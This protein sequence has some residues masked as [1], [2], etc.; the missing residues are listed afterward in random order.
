MDLKNLIRVT[1]N[2]IPVLVPEGSTILDAAKRAEVYI[3]TLCHLKLDDFGIENKPSSCRV[4]MVEV[5]GR[6]RLCTACSETA[7]DGMVVSTNSQR[8]LRARRT[9]VELLLSNHPQLCLTCAKNMDCELQ[10]LAHDIGC[11]EITYSGK[12]SHHPDD[13]TSYS[14]ISHPDKCIMCRRCETMCNEV[15]TVGVL[16]ALDRGF[17]TVVRTA[18]HLDMTETSCTKCGQC[19]AV[20]PTGALT[21]TN[22]THRVWRALQDPSKH[23]VVQVAPAVRVALGEMFGM[24]A[25][26]ISTGKIC[27]ALRKLGF[28]GIFDTDWAAD[29]TIMEEA[30]EIVH[31]LSTPGS[32][33][34]IL[35]SCCPAWVYFV[36]SQF[37]DMLDIP[38]TCK[39]PQIM[40]GTMA[41]TYYA[42]QK[43]LDPKDIVVVSIMPC[44]A[45]K[46]EARRPELMN[47]GMKDVDIVVT[48]REFG[49]MLIEIGLDLNQMTD[50]NFDS[51]MGESTGA[52]IIFGTT[53]GVI[54]AALRT[55]S[56][57][58]T[59]EPLKSVELTSL[60]GFDGIREGTVTIGDRDLHVGIAHGLGNAR[61]LLEGIR[62]GEFHYDAIEIMAC[63]GGCIGGGG[64]PYHHGDM[65]ILLKRQQAIYREDRGKMIRKSHE[66]PMI[67]KI[68]DEYLGE[69]Y[70][71]KAHELLHT[72][73]TP[74]PRI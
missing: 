4:C 73:Y 59:G 47:D 61:R 21:E 13:E 67:K 6:P 54:E 46:S 33:L 57:W 31:R 20:C 10:K 68:Y 45:K 28:D 2:D 18:F 8:A 50:S 24:A 25:G 30:S 56:E 29:L 5:E 42:E 16:S 38:S 71:P 17:S 66:N 62:D 48:T 27:T 74:K 70:G 32:T 1:I 26:T 44:L 39:S 23:V 7:T 15:Q 69:P 12:R 35:T 14:V 52:S 65:E 9:N 49:H 37:P 53:G 55:A 51:I 3:P 72:T 63:P 60:R 43:G 58:I 41:K 22:C 34:P 40:F 19:V 11:R 64:Q 36:E